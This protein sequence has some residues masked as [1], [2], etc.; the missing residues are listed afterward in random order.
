[1]S[2][3]A[4]QPDLRAD[5]RVLVLSPTPTHPQDFGN[6]KRIFRICSRFAG[7]GMRVTFAH[8]PSEAEWRSRF[9]AG[10]ERAMRK[11]WDQYHTIPPTQILHPDPAHLRH[12]I[13]EWWD[14][15]IGQFL[16]WIFAVQ[17]FDIF[18]VNYSWLSKAF[19]YAPPSVFKI[20]DTHDKVSGRQEMLTSLGIRPEFF[21][22]TEDEEAIAL[23]RADLVWAIKGEER[24]LFERMTSTPILTVPHLDPMQTLE[25]TLPDPDGYLR[26]GIIGARNNVNRMNIVEFMA[27]ALPAFEA[28]FAPVKIVIAGTVC[29]LLGDVASPFVELRGHVDDVE[30]FYQSV[31]CVAVPMRASTGLKIKTG[32]ALSLGLP[33]LSLAHAFEGYEPTDPR[34]C[35]AD[36][37]ALADAVVDLSFEPRESLN[38]LAEAS[39]LA[40]AK[41]EAQIVAS[42]DATK[43]AVRDAAH[44]IVLAVDARAFVANSLLNLLLHST[45]DYLRT[46]GNVTVMVVHGSA[47]HMTGSGQIAD[48]LDRLVVARDL[49]GADGHRETLSTLGAGVVDVEAFLSQARPKILVVDAL[50]PALS[51]TP[52]PDTVAISRAEPIALSEGGAATGVPGTNCAQAFVAA[53]GP[54]PAAV[55][56]AIAAEASTVLSPCFHHA[57]TG[58][59]PAQAVN[60]RKTIAILGAPDALA[61]TVA[62]AMA[63]AWNM[64]PVLVYGLEDTAAA[65]AAIRGSRVDDYLADLHSLRAARPHFGI[66]FSAGRPGLLLC[67]EVLERLQVPMVSG[68]GTAPH[69]SLSL[70]VRPFQAGSEQELWEAFRSF[71]IDSDASRNAIFHHAWG[72]LEYG[73]WAWFERCCREQ[74]GRSTSPSVLSGEMGE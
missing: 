54:S 30:D 9:P 63:R 14:D 31:D 45:H 29:D 3:R 5:L 50:H 10:A 58:I 70:G 27:I 24:A 6:R 59:R 19:E 21:Y 37:A 18:V 39:K 53:P 40:Y 36:F 32:E 46:F 74:F 28:A 41:T 25:Q 43:E 57:L 71:A 47:A 42:L 68:C 22:T 16:T 8:Y 33:L 73:N 7:Q 23:R 4:E 2:D 48:R 15:S 60:G 65:G 34:H 35:L 61:V 1:M 17:S 52:L 69:P 51:S 26:V 13:D 11:C 55:N 49:D 67:R 20:L 62:A 64:D 12:D 72:Y 56:M 66:D 44:S 38:V